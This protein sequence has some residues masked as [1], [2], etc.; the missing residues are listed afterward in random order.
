MPRPATRQSLGI[1]NGAPSRAS[2]DGTSCRSAL[3]NQ[4]RLVLHAAAYWLMLIVRDGIGHRAEFATLR[5][6]PLKIAAR[7]RNPARYSHSGRNRL[8]LRPIARLILSK[9]VEK[10]S[11]AGGQTSRALALAPWLEHVSSQ[12]LG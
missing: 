4:V 2:R 1:A 10:V 11:P 7:V 9:R 3:A 8:G 6:R 12:K 5:L